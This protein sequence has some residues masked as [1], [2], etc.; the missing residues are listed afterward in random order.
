MAKSASPVSVRQAPP[1]VRCY[2]LMGRASL[3]VWLL[4][5]GTATSATKRR[6][7][8]RCRT[9]ATKP[10]KTPPVSGHPPKPTSALHGIEL[11][12]DAGH[13]VSL[14]LTVHRVDQASRT[15]IRPVLVDVVHAGLA[16]VMGVND[17]P[18]DWY[19]SEHRP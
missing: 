11:P 6:I 8:D 13:D 12:S 4:V 2:I 14:F 5:K 19:L 18:A 3:S 1:E 15:N 9:V 16:G 10:V 7:M 17:G